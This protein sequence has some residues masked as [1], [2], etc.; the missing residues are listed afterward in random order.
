[1]VNEGTKDR[2]FTVDTSSNNL[3]INENTVKVKNLE[4]YFKERIDRDMGNIVD[5]FED[6][7]LKAILAAIDNNVA[8]K[9][10]LTIRS[11][12]ASSG[13][14]VTSVAANSDR[15]ELVRISASFENAF[16]NSK[17]LHVPNVNNET[18]HN[19]PDEVSGLSVPETDFDR[20]TH[21]HHTHQLSLLLHL[22]PSPEACRKAVD[23]WQQLR[24]SHKKVITR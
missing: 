15:G 7:I 17:L 6:R 11:I 22:E 20:Q 23:M 18:R 1:M 14:D 19:F 8:P 21:T 3:A 9:I 12:N 10:E 24:T 16:G 4:M 2:D 13:P 5:T